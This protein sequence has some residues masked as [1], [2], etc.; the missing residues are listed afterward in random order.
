MNAPVILFVYNRVD[1]VCTC[2]T[3]LEQNYLVDETD[4]YIFS[5]G[6]KSEKDEEQVK[7]VRSYLNDYKYISKFNKVY[8]KENEKNKGLASSVISGV[9]YVIDKCGKA[10]VVE[11]DL[12]VSKDFLEYMN[13]GLDYYESDKR[14]GSISA[15]TYPLNCLNDYV[16]DI[17][18]LRKGDCWGWA[19]WR[20]RWEHVD[21]TVS[22]YDELISERNFC[23]EFN[24]LQYDF[25]RLLIRW[26]QGKTNSWAIRWC[27]HLFL[28]N[29]LTVYPRISRVEN[30]G[31]DGTG[32]NCGKK[33]ESIIRI[34]SVESVKR[35]EF[36][37]LEV[38]IWLEKKVA[39]YEKT[40]LIDII[41]LIYSQL[42]K[43]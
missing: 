2:L 31:Q 23:K 7:A 14:F 5:D 18:V 41:Q 29:Q 43:K 40:K 6:N 9:S 32:T 4:L 11:D 30:I 33:N 28:N 12:I 10:I 20:D 3:S 15:Y 37:D 24:K 36:K 17:Y 38:N 39:K 42:R 1:K 8:I 35:C 22:N 16:E 26:K 19:T 25:T 13:A 34:R 21:W 27:L